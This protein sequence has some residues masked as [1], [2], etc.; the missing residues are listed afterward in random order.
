M[1][2]S[3]YGPMQGAV[4]KEGLSEDVS[5]KWMISALAANLWGRAG[6]DEKEVK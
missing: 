4:A 2:P 6:N 1:G 3:Y 5:W